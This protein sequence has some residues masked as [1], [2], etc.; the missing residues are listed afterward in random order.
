MFP[1]APSPVRSVPRRLRCYAVSAVAGAIAAAPALFAGSDYPIQPVP[2]TAVSFTEGLWHDRQEINNRVTLPFAL[3]QLE[4]SKRLQN[5]DLAADILKRR[6]AG[7]TGAQHK[8]VTVYPFDDSDVYKVLEGAAFCL[9]V[10]PDPKLQA[11]L[12]T[13]IARVAAAQEPDGYLYTWRTMHPDSPAHEWIGQKRWE[14]DPGLS[15]E[16]YIIGHL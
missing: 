4:T 2:F 5:F 11:E 3:G 9:S 13:I 16:L 10:R 8:P 15:H 14:K 1:S 12:E 6:A 7:E